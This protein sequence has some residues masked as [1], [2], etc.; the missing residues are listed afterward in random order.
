MFFANDALPNGLVGFNKPAG[1][2]PV[3]STVTRGPANHEKVTPAHDG[4]ADS[5]VVSCIV[6]LRYWHSR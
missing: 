1:E 3:A 6:T 4:S 2:L 5:D